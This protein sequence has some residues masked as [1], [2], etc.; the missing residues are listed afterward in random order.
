MTI[1]SDFVHTLGLH[2]PRFLNIN[3]T[4]QRT[5]NPAY[6]GALQA[7]NPAYAATC[8]RQAN[9]RLLDPAFVAAGLGANRL[10]QINMFSTNNRSRFDS[11]ATTFK[12]RKSNM[13]F[14]ASY[15][16]AY[17]KAWGG[18]PTA[19]YSGNGIVITPENQFAEGEYGPTRMDERHRIVLSGVI[20]LPYGFQ[21]SPILQY[22]SPRP[23]SANT[24]FDIDG[25]GVATIDRLC[26]GV[27]PAAAFAVRGNLAALQALNPLGCKQAPVN[28]LRSG[29]IVKGAEI[30]ERSHRFF[31]VDMRVSKIFSFGERYRLSLNAD[32]F[33]LFNTENLAYGSNARLGLNAATSASTFLQPTSLYGPGFGPPIG[34]PFTAQFGARFTF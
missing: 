21:I 16:L 18:Q 34:R 29:F 15:V 28:S 2:E 12:Y 14:N 9:T 26:A 10:S 20:G 1:S 5:C 32:F 19:S 24:G 13:S 25:D 23:F 8:P 33:N 17:S 30:E 11:W 6:P 27:D 4:I 22:G 3:P 7:N 31:N